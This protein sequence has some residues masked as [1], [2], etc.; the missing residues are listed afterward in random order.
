MWQDNNK[1]DLRE[2]SY[3]DFYWSGIQVHE[4]WQVLALALLNL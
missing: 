4:K 3:E 1:T 2:V